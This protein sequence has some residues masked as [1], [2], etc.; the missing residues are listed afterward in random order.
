MSEKE[1]I[2]FKNEENGIEVSVPDGVYASG[3]FLKT[4]MHNVSSAA[5]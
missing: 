3:C 1:T 5:M 4:G 2:H